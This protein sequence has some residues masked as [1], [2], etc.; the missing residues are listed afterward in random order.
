QSKRKLFDTRPIAQR[1]ASA[2]IYQHVDGTEQLNVF[3]KMDSDGNSAS[4]GKDDVE[5]W[6][7]FA[8]H[9]ETIMATLHCLQG[10]SG[11]S[12]FRASTRNISTIPAVLGNRHMR[13]KRTRRTTAYFH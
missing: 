5:E 10:F 12:R 2:L 9:D 6:R 11:D 7:A 13:A 4:A 3:D 8:Q 1:R